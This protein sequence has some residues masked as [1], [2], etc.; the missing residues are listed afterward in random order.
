MEGTH[1]KKGTLL[2]IFP[3][4]SL[5]NAQN[6]PKNL[7]FGLFR[8]KSVPKFVSL[9]ARFRLPKVTICPL[10]LATQKVSL[11]LVI[12]KVGF[13]PFFQTKTG[14]KGTLFEGHF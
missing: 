6:D 8:L 10:F 13:W 1:P 9:F 14:L 5:K 4:K 7:N 3:Q 11:F 2:L 12:S